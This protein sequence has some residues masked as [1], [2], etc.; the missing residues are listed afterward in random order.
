M[1][2]IPN[3]SSALT[4]TFSLREKVFSISWRMVKK[5]ILDKEAIRIEG[6]NL[7]FGGHNKVIDSRKNLRGSEKKYEFILKRLFSFEM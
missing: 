6:Q 2:T 5:V 4:G 7:F 3:P 1:S